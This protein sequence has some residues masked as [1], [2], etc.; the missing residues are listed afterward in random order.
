[1]LRPPALLLCVFLVTGACA[2][3]SGYARASATAE[4]TESY[5]DLVVST[6]EQVGLAVDALRA[7]AENPG[8]SPRSN[9]ETFQTYARELAN[10]E[11]LALLS[12]KTYGKMDARAELFFSGWTE[13]AA[14]ITDAE[15]KQSSEA[16]RKALEAN[17]QKLSEGQRETDQALVHFV[18]QLSDIRLYLEHD[19]T[20][21]GIASAKK[22]IDKAFAEGAALQDHLSALAHASDE[23]RAALAPLRAQA[24]SAP[25]QH[26]R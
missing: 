13:D 5:H 4:K 19:L 25:E 8:D 10:L 14:Q 7:L 20:S 2:S 12:R 26:V 17:Y 23:A 15:L 6:R 18:H 16:R 11:S 24:P 21:D 22:S 3:R 9:Q 1:M